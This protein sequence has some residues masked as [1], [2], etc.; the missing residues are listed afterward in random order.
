[1]PSLTSVPPQMGMTKEVFECPWFRVHEEV[2]DEVSA[3]DR[4][5]F[6]R[7]ESSDGVLIL[8]MTKKEEI[9]LVRQFRH[10][11]RR[12]TLEFPAGTVDGSESPEM[13][14]VRELLEETG[15]RSARFV[16]LGSGHM[17]VN[18]FSSKGY[19]FLAQDCQLDNS[20]SL[21][22]S[23]EVVLVSPGQLKEIVL[24]GK[25]DQMSALSLLSL[26]EWTTGLRLLG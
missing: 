26:A 13:A 4:E 10:A 23:E 12:T 17:M 22:E 11:I 9:I 2:W 7:V 3:F 19:F 18:R 8:A 21:K 20:V 5:P 14:A 24:A 6:Y 15:Y 16:G 25:F 1:M